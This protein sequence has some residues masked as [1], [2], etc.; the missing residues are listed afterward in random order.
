VSREEA[1]TIARA[2]AVEKYRDLSIY[3][4]MCDLKSDGWHVEYHVRAKG[5][6]GGGPFYI[7]DPR[8][9][10]IITKHYYQ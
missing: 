6:Q 3:E 10:V 9:G 8:S 7:I 5:M 2:D 1:L 4:V